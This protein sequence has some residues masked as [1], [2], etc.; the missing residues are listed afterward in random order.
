MANFGPI[1]AEIGSGVFRHPSK[2]QRVSRLGFVTRATSFT[3]GQPNFAR[4]LTVS[5]VSTLYIH[6]R[7]LSPRLNFTT[8]K[9]HFGSKSC[10]PLYWQRYCTSLKQRD[11]PNFAAWYRE[12]NY[13]TFAEGATY[14]RLG[15][16]HV[17][18]RPHSS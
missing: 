9:I 15:G 5:W 13:G 11:Q 4:C 17:G 12:W 2:F 14:I 18:H 7:R 1:A 16:H 8:C 6:F 3:G 10:F